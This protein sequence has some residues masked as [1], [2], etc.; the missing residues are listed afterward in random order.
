MA[1]LTGAEPFDHDGSDTGVLLC[2]GFTGTPQSM[3]PWGQYLAGRGF[4]VHIPLLPGHGTSWQ[5]MNQTRWRDWYSCVD[6][7]FRKLHETC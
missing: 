3:R 4:T 7:A 6:T 5:E 1:I 2:H